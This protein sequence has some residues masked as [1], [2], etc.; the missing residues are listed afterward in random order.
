MPKKHVVGR[1][2]RK[3]LNGHEWELKVMHKDT[4]DGA[5]LDVEGDL[6]CAECNS[7][8]VHSENIEIENDR[9]YGRTLKK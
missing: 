1:Q 7:Y 9:F 2:I 8:A 6:T 4:E 5:I 3:C